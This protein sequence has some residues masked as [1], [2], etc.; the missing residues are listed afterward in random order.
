[1]RPLLPRTTLAPETH[2]LHAGDER[3]CP[4]V[5]DSQTSLSTE[6]RFEPCV[7]FLRDWLSL[8]V[9]VADLACVPL[10]ILLNFV[11][12]DRI[13]RFLVNNFVNH[14]DEYIVWRITK[15]AR[16]AS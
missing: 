6:T 12:G 14:D 16:T 11:G 15:R 4:W 8:L 2:G 10:S 1:M 13:D 3:S 9:E 5:G 7:E